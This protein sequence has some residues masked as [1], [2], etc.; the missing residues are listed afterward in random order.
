MDNHTPLPSIYDSMETIEL[1]EL[2]MSF[3]EALTGDFMNFFTMVSAYMVVAYLAGSTLTRLQTAMVTVLYSIV[4]LILIAGS[5]QLAD[6]VQQVN[7][8][9]DRGLSIN[10][11]LAVLLVLSSMWLMSLLFMFQIRRQFK[12]RANGGD[13]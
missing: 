9:L 12:S 1:F 4:T 10:L 3:R 11:R 2:A 13:T 5:I 8:I 6:E 7:T